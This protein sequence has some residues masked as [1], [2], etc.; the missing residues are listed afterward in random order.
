[1]R[2]IFVLIVLGVISLAGPLAAKGKAKRAPVKVMDI[3][4]ALVVKGKVLKPRVM[5]ILNKGRIKYRGIPLRE[6][7]IKRVELPLKEDRF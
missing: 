5:Y 6:D 2:S 1:M 4:D 3:K 7:F